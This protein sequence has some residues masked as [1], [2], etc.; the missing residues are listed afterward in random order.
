MVRRNSIR[1]FDSAALSP[2]GAG[3]ATQGAGAGSSWD[4]AVDSSTIARQRHVV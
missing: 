4:P 2:G 1:L 3:W